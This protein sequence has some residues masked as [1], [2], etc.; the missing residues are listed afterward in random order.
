MLLCVDRTD[1]ELTDETR[2]GQVL[3]GL[4]RPLLHPAL[5]GRWRDHGLT[6]VSLD[7]LP[8]TLSRTAWL[9]A[10]EDLHERAGRHPVV[11]EY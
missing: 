2:D 11:D 6:A 1:P 3:V 5:V 7:L 4:L 9:D 8:R 10:L